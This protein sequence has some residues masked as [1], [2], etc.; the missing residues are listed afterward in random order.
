VEAPVYASII[1]AALLLKIGG[2]GILRIIN[3]LSVS[4]ATKIIQSYAIVGRALISLLCIVQID[5]KVII[6]YSSVAHMGLVCAC[7]VDIRKLGMLAGTALILAHAISSAGIF[8][9]ANFIYLN[10]NRRSII[11]NSGGLAIQPWF[12]LFL[13][14]LCLGNMAAP[15]TLNLVSEIWC[16]RAILCLRV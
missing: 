13:F 8:T 2:Y 1:L 16:L 9:G 10:T 6:A 14:L 12:T 7:F 4:R 11:L 3:F 5:I 15:P